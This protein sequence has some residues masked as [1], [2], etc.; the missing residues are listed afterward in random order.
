[1]SG[2]YSIS[3]ETQPARRKERVSYDRDAVH[4]V[5]D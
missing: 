1:M 4:A 5:L 2:D 3:A